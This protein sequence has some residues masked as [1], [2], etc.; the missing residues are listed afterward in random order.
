M[1]GSMYG[2]VVQ[3]LWSG[4]IDYLN[5]TIRVALVDNAYTPDQD[6]DAYFS[7]VIVNEASGT[8][9]TAGGRA[10]ANKSVSYTA[11]TNTLKLDADDIVWVNTTLAARYAVVYKDTGTPA[12]SNLIGYL[13]F[14][15]DKETN[16][17]DF[18]V[19]WSTS[20]VI[21]HGVV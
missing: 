3:Q 15:V 5:D 14:S 18:T 1:A 17:G 12:T 9:Y 19:V 8:G 20:G 4:G 13:D 2:S 10:L 21:S 7:E 11:A 6:N 16:D